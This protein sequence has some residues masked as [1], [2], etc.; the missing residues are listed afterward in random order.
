MG[1]LGGG[2]AHFFFPKAPVHTVGGACV[3]QTLSFGKSSQ[4]MRGGWK[5]WMFHAA[6]ARKL[7]K[8]GAG[9]NFLC[10]AINRAPPE[11]CCEN[12]I[13]FNAVVTFIQRCNF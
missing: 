11:G 7:L 4:R 5:C 12:D 10:A 6:C 13:F 1:F 3:F 9:I 2:G 8:H